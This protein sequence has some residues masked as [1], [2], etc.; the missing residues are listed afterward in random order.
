MNAFKFDLSHPAFKDVPEEVLLAFV[1]L[2]DLHD[3]QLSFDKELFSLLEEVIDDLPL[4]ET[5]N[6]E[7]LKDL[8][9][10]LSGAQ[11]VGRRSFKIKHGT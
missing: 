5:L 1:T 7:E 2:R 10:M 4:F 8:T 6:T 9:I 3:N 11:Q